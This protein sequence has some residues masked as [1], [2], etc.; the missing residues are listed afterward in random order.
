[1]DYDWRWD[2]GYKAHHGLVFPI[3]HTGQPEEVF[4]GFSRCITCSVHLGDV[5][6]LQ[7]TKTSIVANCRREKESDESGSREGTK[8]K[9][10]QTHSGVS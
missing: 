8:R 10:R 2:S 5:Q 9:R 7:P 6:L 1:M 3:Q 4:F